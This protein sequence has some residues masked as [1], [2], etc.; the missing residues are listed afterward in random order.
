MC[1]RDRAGTLALAEFYDHC[2]RLN[3]ASF[4]FMDGTDSFYD[5]KVAESI[6]RRLIAIPGVQILTATHNTNLLSNDI[7]RPDCYFLLKENQIRPLSDLTAKE[8]RRAHNLQKMYKA[9]E[10]DM[11]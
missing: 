3:D 5:F 1:I 2:L 8:L 9:G 4:V 7:L 10:F 6:Q 11:K